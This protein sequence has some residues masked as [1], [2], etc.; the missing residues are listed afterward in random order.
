MASG[1]GHGA[2]GNRHWPIA[3]GALACRDIGGGVMVLEHFFLE[4]LDDEA[5]WVP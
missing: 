5:F 4:H 1:M 2:Q 3:D